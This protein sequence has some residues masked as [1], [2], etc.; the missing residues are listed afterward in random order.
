MSTPS[1]YY[2]TQR[3]LDGIKGM[4]FELLMS[5]EVASLDGPM[6]KRLSDWVLGMSPDEASVAIQALIEG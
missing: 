3:E 2:E 1:T 4:A 6:A 5:D